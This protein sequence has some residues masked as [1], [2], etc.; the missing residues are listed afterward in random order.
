MSIVCI[1]LS[2]NVCRAV[3]SDYKGHAPLSE[4]QQEKRNYYSN[5][6]AQLQNL[7]TLKQVCFVMEEYFLFLSLI[8]HGGLPHYH[9]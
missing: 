2:R 5:F 7:S 3:T 6:L 4:K 1:G 8:Q 9:A